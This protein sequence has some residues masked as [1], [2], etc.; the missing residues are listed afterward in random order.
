MNEHDR[1]AR[2]ALKRA[3]QQSETARSGARPI[4]VPRP[5]DVPR[6][7]APTERYAAVAPIDPTE[8]L[9]EEPTRV[10]VVP[11][12]A[13]ALRSDRPPPISSSALA[14]EPPPP[15]VK[16]HV[17]SMNATARFGAVDAAA[18]EAPPPPEAPAVD[19]WKPIETPSRARTSPSS[20]IELSSSS[21]ATEIALTAVD[22]TASPRAATLRT[23][24]VPVGPPAWLIWLGTLALALVAIAAAL[25]LS[26]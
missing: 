5:T 4:S 26:R 12:T 3:S 23:R 11:V 24:Q 19:R 7:E 16:T 10:G 6:L 15:A 22:A 21:R 8:L 17:P 2:I 13:L 20:E 1:T 9:P 14:S 25:A 18:L